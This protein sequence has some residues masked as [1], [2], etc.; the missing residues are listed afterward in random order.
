MKRVVY[1]SFVKELKRN[2]DADTGLIQVVTGPRQV[3][4]T[5]TILK[6]IE[7]SYPSDALYVSADDTF[8][9]N[10]EWLTELWLSAITSNKILF[11]DEIQKCHNWAS[12][13]KGLYDRAKR[14]KKSV[15]CVLLGSS[16]LSIQRGLTESLTGRFQL[17][18]AHHWNF[19]ESQEGYGLS[20]EDYLKFGGYPGSYPLIGEPQWYD[21][22]LNSIVLTVVDKDI[23]LFNS[24]KNPAL[25]K[26]AFEILISYPAQEISY[27][28][29]LGQLQEGGN[30]ELV[31]YYISLYAGAYLI[32]PLDKFFNKAT[33][34][35]GSSPKVLPLA[36]ALPYLQIRDEYTE[37]ERGRVFE[38][39]VGSQLARTGEP[40]FYWREGRKEVDFVLKV[41][42]RIYGVEVKSSAASSSK[43]LLAFQ[44]KFPRAK[45]ALV[46]PDQYQDFES[47]P[48]SFLE[49]NSV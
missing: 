43:G 18:R 15:H 19:S 12:T 39:L 16:S 29:L 10:A 13:L 27:T 32:T 25:F 47:D 28:K 1:L 35:K 44:E 42:R 21:Y 26:Q 2:L 3:G 48:L 49:S 46:T 14:E 40:L 6:L 8:N 36:P 5:T 45:V 7:D 24:V 11:I 30:V 17:T 37:Q 38:L 33:L 22:V 34:R 9:P 20:F 41:G 4:K 31:K 23:L